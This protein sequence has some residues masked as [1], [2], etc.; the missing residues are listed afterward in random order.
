MPAYRGLVLFLAVLSAA[1]CSSGGGTRAVMTPPPSSPPPSPP[2]PSPPPSTVDT[3][4][5][6]RQPALAQINAT[7]AYE[8]GLFGSGGL[9]AF[10]DTGIDVSNAEFAGRIDPRSAD[11][12]VSGVV[13]SKD[14]RPGGPSLQDVDGHGTAVASIAGAAKN[15][16]G[17]HGVAPIAQLLIFRADNPADSAELLGGAI[18]EGARRAASYGADVL[19][20]SLGSDEADARAGFRSIFAQ[21]A[22]GDVF[23]AISAGNDSMTEPDQSALAALDPEAAGTVIVVG[24]VNSLNVLASFSNQ[25]GAA[26]NVFIV[27]PGVNLNATA[28]GSSSLVR[29]SGTS[30]AAPLVAGAAMLL[31]ARWPQLSAAQTAT[32]LLSSATDLGA[33]GTDPVYGR[34]L[35]NIGD[36][37][38]PAGATTT[39]TSSGSSVS[40]NGGSAS[41]GPVFGSSL[42]AFGDYVFLDSYGRDYRIAFNPASLSAHGAL[43]DPAATLAPDR[44]VKTAAVAVGGGLMRL[45]EETTELSRTEPEAAL[46][47][48]FGADALDAE[49]RERFAVAFSG[50]TAGAVRYLFSSG[51]AAAELDTLTGAT[52]WR[53]S[54]SREGFADAYLGR[55]TSALGGVFSRDLGAGLSID[56]L[57]A[58]TDADADIIEFNPVDEL[59]LA[60]SLERREQ[61]LR[62]LRLGVDRRFEGGRVRYEVG[63]RAEDGGP[64]GSTFGGALAGA[65]ASVTYYQTA[66]AEIG[67]ADGWSLGA[68]GSVGLTSATATGAGFFD[69]I[70]GLVTTH[71]A[72]TV[73]GAGVALDGDRLAISAI[74]PLR[75]ESG[76]LTLDAPTGYDL[77]TRS[78]VFENRAIALGAGAREIDVEARYEAPLAGGAVEAAV[79]HQ[80]NA[81][82]AGAS[83]T[84]AIVRARF[85]F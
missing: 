74:Q 77:A 24:A 15:D 10:I 25:A 39:S 52:A 70:D 22:A 85:A 80:L 50:A 19:S 47:A 8:D 57:V 54:L 21:T 12:V 7:P 61:G 2:P 56:A 53:P 75:A 58:Q 79:L 5:F 44:R 73:A 46:R 20:L 18:F 51:F 33:P 82:F 29:F 32:I 6:R 78:L 4:E 66:I 71:F 68:R 31:R 26:A 64:F 27:A 84:S 16:V 45:R 28:I 23:T 48:Q 41:F 40:V 38:G 35:L 76:R 81:P 11:L 62:N 42:P 59:L 55:T 9:L 1:A 3:A 63:V 49:R 13:A 69:S 72:A 60:R 36:A 30:A 17:I 37:L 43:H 65:D 67:L 14:V 34:G 83:A